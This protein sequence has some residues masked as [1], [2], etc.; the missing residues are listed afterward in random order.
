MR[1]VWTYLVVVVVFA[2]GFLCASA[3]TLGDDTV[4]TKLPWV[5]HRVRRWE[6]EPLRWLG[7]H[8]M[9]TLYRAAD[10]REQASQQPTTSILARVAD[11][12]TG[13]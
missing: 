9:Y 10:R 1:F 6:P 2:F 8:A 5:G 12:I 13:R 4:L 11:R 7:V 3:F